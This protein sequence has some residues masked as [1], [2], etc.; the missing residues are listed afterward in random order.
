MIY[1][2]GSLALAALEFFVH[3]P[4]GISLAGFVAVSA[5]IPDRLRIETLDVA[6]LPAQ[7]RNHKSIET[8]RDLG[9]EWLRTRSSAV[10]AVPSAVIPIEANYLLNPAHKDFERV[11]VNPLQPFEFD[12]RMWK[13]G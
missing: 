8:L 7:R 13:P 1:T 3:L 5:D 11:R 4:P 12:Y 10:L 9:T 2:G 6:K